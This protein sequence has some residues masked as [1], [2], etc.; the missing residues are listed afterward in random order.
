MDFSKIKLII[1]DL[2]E[3]FWQGILS[4]NTVIYDNENEQLIKDATDAGVINSIC[5]KND[6][7]SV[8]SFLS[9]CGIWDYFVFNSINWSSKGERVKQIIS[10]MNLRDANVLF[11]DDNHLNLQEVKQTCPNIMVDLPTIIVELKEYFKKAAKKDLN[12]VRLNQYKVLE[13]KVE[14]KAASGSNEEFLRN[15]NI[16]VNIVKSG[17]A[18][19]IDRIYDLVQRSNQ[20]NFTKVRSSKE[21]LLEL[22]NDN[23]IDIGYVEVH[24]NFGDYGLVGFYAI[25]DEVAIHF[26]FSC[27]TL[28]MG[29]EQ[30]VYDF[31][32]R[33]TVNIVGEV[34]SSLEGDSPNWIN[35]RKKT[36]KAKKTQLDSTK[37]VIKGPCDLELVFSF[38]QEN[39]NTIKEF[40]YVGKNGVSIEGGCHTTHIVQAITTD[41]KTKKNLAENLPFGDEDMFSTAIF[42]P[43]VDVIYLSMLTD[44]NL[45]L[46]KEKSTGLIVAFGEWVNDFTNEDIWDDVIQK[47]VFTANCEF[48]KAQLQT[49][50]NDYEFLG[51]ISPEKIVE[52]L[53]CIY[54]KINPNAKLVLNLGSEIA[55]KNNTQ[56]AYYDRHLYHKEMN[57]LIREWKQDKQNVFLID[58]SKHIKSQEDYTNNINHFAKSVY[59]SL[60]QELIKIIGDDSIK[61]RQKQ[62]S[63]IK[64]KAEKLARILSS[65]LRKFRK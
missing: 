5:S 44:P 30:Y 34:A 42:E 19:K 46:Y 40:V 55:Y 41:E 15:C 63:T 3:T 45:G 14:F 29:V 24:D 22:C 36:S 56:P 6:F 7:D 13:K 23:S 39:K 53:Q 31:L 16:Q 28:N 64:R 48:T 18:E 1:W 25:K 2:D 49:L 57:K 26:V 11:I 61:I 20:L 33:P 58:I 17:V 54:S 37:L 35:S 38:I 51:R 43:D 59:H 9:E 60:A 52:N 65:K 32:N 21:E 8:K 47:K 27:R 62:K 12:H 10:E 50:K 4:D